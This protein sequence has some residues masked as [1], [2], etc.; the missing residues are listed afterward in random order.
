MFCCVHL[1]EKGSS[2]VNKQNVLHL[3][4]DQLALSFLIEVMLLQSTVKY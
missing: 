4:M 2:A 1:S 3:I